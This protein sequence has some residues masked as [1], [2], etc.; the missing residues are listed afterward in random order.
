MKLEIAAVMTP[1]AAGPARAEALIVPG[2]TPAVLFL[3]KGDGRTVQIVLS[4]AEARVLGEML[5]TCG[6]VAEGGPPP[7]LDPPAA[8]GAPRI[9]HGG[10]A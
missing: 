9:V 8:S 4:S 1:D 5:I 10:R 7:S 6:C 3:A 2:P